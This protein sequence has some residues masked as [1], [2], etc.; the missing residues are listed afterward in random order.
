MTTRWRP[1]HGL[2]VHDRTAP[3]VDQPFVRHAAFA[4]YLEA[5]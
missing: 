5:G 3:I 4:P 1:I 2:G